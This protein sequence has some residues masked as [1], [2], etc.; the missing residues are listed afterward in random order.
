[1]KLRHI[2]PFSILAVA[3]T[4]RA[5][6]LAEEIDDIHRLDARIAAGAP[7]LVGRAARMKQA[8]I[9]HAIVA[10]AIDTRSVPTGVHY[11]PHG[12][13]RE[14]EGA[15]LVDRDGTLRVEIGDPAFRS[16]GWL[17]STIAHEVEVHVNR[18]VARGGHTSA[19]DDESVSIEEIQAY[20]FELA[21]G[22]RFGLEPDELDV[23]RHRRMALYRT[24]QYENR[25]RVDS[26]VY[27]KW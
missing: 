26:G 20:D 13:M 10:Y 9:Q 21:S 15:T 3:G 4:A 14:R 16:A 18:Q 11:S 23:L 2:V 5:A 27:I 7:E 22:A 6:S 1:M 12:S 17:G 25:R 8:A 19:S 24:L